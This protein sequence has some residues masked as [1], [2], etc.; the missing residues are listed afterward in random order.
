MATLKTHVPSLLLRGL[1]EGRIDLCALALE[2]LVPPLSLLVLLLA[3]G[4]F[5]CG[6]AALIGASTFPL[7]LFTFSLLSIVVGVLAGWLRYGKELVSPRDLL[8]IPKYILW[9]LP[10]Y[11][12]FFTRG[13]Q[14]SWER[15][16]RTQNPTSKAP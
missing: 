7:R 8:S 13:K 2:L 3:A 16:E 14:A 11:F 15:T 4:W 1:N 6:A 5:L 12:T 9:K 10:L